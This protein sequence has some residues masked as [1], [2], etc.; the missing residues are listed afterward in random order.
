VIAFY[1]TTHLSNCGKGWTLNSRWAIELPKPI[2]TKMCR[3]RKLFSRSKI[4][5]SF[6]TG[7]FQRAT[8]NI[9]NKRGPIGC[10]RVNIANTA[11]ALFCLQCYFL[12]GIWVVRQFVGLECFMGDRENFVLNV[13]IIVEPMWGFEKIKISRHSTCSRVENKLFVTV[14]DQVDREESCEIVSY[15]SLLSSEWLK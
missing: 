14:C 12:R 3:L 1:K 11:R 7:T 6:H 9:K 8:D 10:S 4:S 2:A 15:K 13:L 5:T